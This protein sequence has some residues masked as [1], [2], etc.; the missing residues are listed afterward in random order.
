MY[1]M[2][3]RVLY[4]IVSPDKYSPMLCLWANCMTC[5]SNNP[6]NCLSCFSNSYLVISN[7]SNVTNNCTS[8]NA[9]ANCLTCLQ[10]N[11]SNCTS[12][13]FGYYLSYNTY[14]LGTCVVSCPSNCLT[15]YNSSNTTMQG[16]QPNN[17][18]CSSCFD[19]YGLSPTGAC[20]PCQYNCRVCSGQ[21]QQ[22]C[23]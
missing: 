9:S 22:L 21:Y 15:C 4:D 6:N 1:P 10:S 17:I 16:M 20:L 11:S 14:G 23:I 5:S 3:S 19:G 18:V 2:F 7:S 8:C 12:C 13:P